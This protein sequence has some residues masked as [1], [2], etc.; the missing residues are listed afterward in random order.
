MQ[1]GQYNSTINTTPKELLESQTMKK[2]LMGLT[3]LFL[4]CLVVF[5]HGG[6]AIVE[7][8]KLTE[9]LPEPEIRGAEFLIKEILVNVVHRRATIVL[10][11]ITGKLEPAEDLPKGGTYYTNVWKTAAYFCKLPTEVGA[12]YPEDILKDLWIELG[13][14]DAVLV[15]VRNRRQAVIE[16]VNSNPLILKS[17]ASTVALAATGKNSEQTKKMRAPLLHM[18]DIGLAYLINLDEDAEQRWYDEC[19][20]V[21]AESLEAGNYAEYQKIQYR[22]NQYR[23]GKFQEGGLPVTDRWIEAFMFRRLQDGLS[24]E[25]LMKYLNVLAQSLVVTPK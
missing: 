13:A 11:A 23:A 19:Q 3:A 15:E 14:S 6:A 21:I 16:T 1:C 9:R 24:K 4:A 18:I 25:N 2:K 10:E 22:F 8:Q 12:G 20:G 7:S 17:L 5:N